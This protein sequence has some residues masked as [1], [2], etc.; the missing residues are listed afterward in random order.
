MR[1]LRV[2]RAHPQ[3]TYVLDIETTG[4]GE[5]VARQAPKGRPPR[6]LL[7]CI[8]D[9]RE[10]RSFWGESAIQTALQWI[11]DQDEDAE[12]F[13]HYGGGFDFRFAH[14]WLF[15]KVK[16][17]GRNWKIVTS[18][19]FVI[20][21]QGIVQ[22][23]R[24]RL[25]DSIRLLPGSL[26]AIGKEIGIAKK[27]WEHRWNEIDG[28]HRIVLYKSICY[29]AFEEYCQNDCL[30]LW[31]GIELIRAF[32]A[33][34]GINLRNTLASTATASIRRGLTLDTIAWAPPAATEAS[35]KACFGG[36]V[37]VF[38][39]RCTKGNVFDIQSSYPFAMLQNLPWR[40]VETRPSYKRG[41]RGIVEAE[42]EVPEQR[43]PVL[44]YRQDHGPDKGRVFF[45]TGRWTGSF[46]SRELDY[47]VKLGAKIVAVTAFHRFEGSEILAKFARGGWKERKIAQGFKRYALKIWLNSVYGKL[48]EATEHEEILVHPPSDKIICERHR[49]VARRPDERC[50]CKVPIVPSHGIY[51]LETEH[52]P[53]FRA[54][55]AAAAIT[56]IARMN[57]HKRF[58]EALMA[59]GQLYYCDTDSVFTDSMLVTGSDLGDL[60]LERKIEDGRFI[61]PK[62]YA[63]KCVDCTKSE[64][65][66][67][68]V[69]KSKGFTRLSR[70]EFD[71]LDR[72]E[73]GEGFRSG[74]AF[75]CPVCGGRSLLEPGSGRAIHHF[76]RTEG[77]KE[78]LARGRI[79]YRRIKVSRQLSV[80]RAKRH[81]E[82]RAWTLEE[83]RA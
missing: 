83:L 33:S 53:A 64:E 79:D 56:A 48:N 19:S 15:R 46:Y 9:G 50:G 75:G 13:A 27:E 21:C 32:A 72:C 38:E 74:T 66:P 12:V 80:T 71:R 76:D 62:M 63:F 49:E 51:A 73:C 81:P 39:E 54:P 20:V 60:T 44:P 25:V 26:K 22:G 8:Y 36:R 18:G 16:G 6:Q 29:K 35:S 61:G 52:D 17:S 57:L 5:P 30:I 34:K 3:R 4:L 37:E 43:V 40:Y 7:C 28:K 58:M 59:G 11:I 55:W 2:D 41:M 77:F 14:D 10:F 68:D 23:I 31:K 65:H 1:P 82:G 45:P 24:L 78:A 67:H 69:V 70:E 42:V 47:A